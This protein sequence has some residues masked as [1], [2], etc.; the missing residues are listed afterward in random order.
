MSLETYQLT[1]MVIGSEERL[2]EY[3]K[4]GLEFAPRDYDKNKY[5]IKVK[6]HKHL[7][8]YQSPFI[9]SRDKT[10]FDYLDYYYWEV[11]ELGFTDLNIIIQINNNDYDNDLI[12]LYDGNKTHY[13]NK[14]LKTDYR[15]FLT[16]L[17][18]FGP[19]FHRSVFKTLVV[20][21]ASYRIN[22]EDR[23]IDY[24][25]FNR[26]DDV[27]SELRYVRSHDTL[28]LLIL[29]N[30]KPNTPT[31]IYI[32]QELEKGYRLDYVLETINK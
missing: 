4:K 25:N 9:R 2:I 6:K 16:C 19:K 5:D 18:M 22:F 29:E 14:I 30:L 8:H 3:D 1:V 10:F 13:R 12:H 27:Q 24:R 15:K 11:K 26:D 7:F 21:D 23:S 32:H 20:Q 28:E 31:E 17:N